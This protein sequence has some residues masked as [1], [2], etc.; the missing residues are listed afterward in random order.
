MSL[1]NRRENI[2]YRCDISRVFTLQYHGEGSEGNEMC[3]CVS[4][5]YGFCVLRGEECQRG[6]NV[7]DFE[8]VL[9]RFL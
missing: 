8:F 2:F 3:V 4:K 9:S 7:K 6:D 5:T 1:T